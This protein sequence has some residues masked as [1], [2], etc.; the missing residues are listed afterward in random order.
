MQES[1][2]VT[3]KTPN[4][5]KDKTGAAAASARLRHDAPKPPLRRD[6][7]TVAAGTRVR[8]GGAVV[9]AHAPALAAA[10]PARHHL[11]GEA[12]GLRG[13]IAKKGVDRQ[14]CRAD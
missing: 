2:V 5:G 13:R 7:H 8:Q 11:P 1:F 10:P 3:T 4:I 14:S 6:L 9:R 12:A